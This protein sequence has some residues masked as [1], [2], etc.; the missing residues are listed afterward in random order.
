MNTRCEFLILYCLLTVVFGVSVSIYNARKNHKPILTWNIFTLVILCP[1]IMPFVLIYIIVKGVGNLYYKDKPRP[2]AKRYRRFLKKDFIEH[3]GA[4]MSLAEYNKK[5]N[6]NVKLEDIYDKKNVD[7]LTPEEIAHFEK[8]ENTLTINDNLPDDIYTKLSVIFANARVNNDYSDLERYLSD[9]VTFVLYKRRTLQGKK[10]FVDYWKSKHFRE[11]KDDII[12]NTE[13]KLCLYYNHAGILDKPKRFKQMYLLFRIYGGKITHAVYAPNPLHDS[14]IP[15][16]DLD[17]PPYDSK[18][19]EVNLGEPIHSEEN[20]IPCLRCGTPSEEL[21][22]HKFSIDRGM[23]GYIGHISV[24][25]RCHQQVEFYPEIMNDLFV[26]KEEG[27]TRLMKT[28]EVEDERQIISPRLCGINIFYYDMTLKGSKYV[29]NLDHNVIVHNRTA[30]LMGVSGSGFDPCS[31]VECV[32]N[33]STLMIRNLFSYNKELYNQC[34]ECYL[35]AYYDGIYEAANNLAIITINVEDNES[36]SINYLI[37]AIDHGSKNAMINLFSILWGA[38]G[39]YNGAIRHLS[40]VAEMQNPSILCLW[41]L[42]VLYHFGDCLPHNLLA[43]N[44]E[45]SKK[46]LEIIICAETEVTDLDEKGIVEKAKQFLEDFNQV[47]AFADKGREFHK[48]LK[49]IVPNTI[50]D[51]GEIFSVLDFLS[52][53]DEY[54]LGLALP[55]Y[56]GIG[57]ESRFYIYGTDGE[58]HN[59]FLN[60]MNVEQKRMGAW[61]IYLMHTSTTVLPV[62]WHGG[63]IIRKFIFSLSD[64]KQI[65]ML[66]GLDFSDFAKENT[67]FPTISLQDQ[68]AYVKCCYWNEW[69]GLVCETVQIQFQNNKVLSVEIVGDEILFKYDC[70]ILF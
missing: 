49:N 7:A 2:I 1:L 46:Y 52:L 4:R 24:C 5:F 55:N 61:Q 6:K 25:L 16:C 56:K 14:L 60:Y 20:R 33:F 39:D 11:E 28:S 12:V 58:K 29:K 45:L 18:T 10:A 22:W 59:D 23:L 57:G 30:E 65:P 21:N 50:Q 51:I 53:S 41:N 64:L 38:D 48:R 69:K 40:D 66:K 17:C 54:K 36:D 15:Y 27:K 13:V 42:A 44:R 37:H 63:Y 8:F 34:K 68:T 47:N 3:N 9:D 31:L 43:E 35:A 67:F 70:G 26:S 62:F 32:E 19:I